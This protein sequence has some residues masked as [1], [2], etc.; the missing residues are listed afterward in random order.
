MLTWSRVSIPLGVVT[1]VV[2]SSC[3]NPL[4]LGLH[5]KQDQD[6]RRTTGHGLLLT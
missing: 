1:L 3:S 6:D 5:Q 2:I 4:P